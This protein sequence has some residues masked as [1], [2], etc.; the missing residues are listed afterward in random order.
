[1]FEPSPASG[2]LSNLID[3]I[4]PDMVVLGGGLIEAMPALLRGE[5]EKAVKA[6]A[7][8][9]AA[10]LAKVVVAKLRGHAGTI[11]AAKLAVDMDRKKPPIDAGL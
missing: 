6:H 7:S 3:F 11:G 1:M 9:A 2:A 5:I 4:N 10:K 8:P